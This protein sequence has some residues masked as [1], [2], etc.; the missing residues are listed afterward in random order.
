MKLHGKTPSIML[1][2]ALISTYF[3]TYL[4]NGASSSEVGCFFIFGDSQSD[5]GNNNNNT[6]FARADYKPYGIDFSKE[7]KPTGRFTNGRN[8]ADFIV[9]FLGFDNY[10]PPFKNMSGWNIL[11]G[12]NYA[13]GAAGIRDE[14]GRTQGER[15]SFNKQL[16]NHNLI[17]SKLQHLLGN[18]IAAE[19]HLK[20]C[21]YMVQIGGNDYLNNYFMPLSYKTSTEFTPHQYATALSKQ[22]SCKLKAL[23][24]Q[25][26]RKLAIF[27]AGPIGCTPYARANFDTKGS[28][29][30]E[31][32]NNAIQLFNIGLKSMVDDL[33]TKLT[34][35][36]F[37]FVDVFNIGT[38]GTPTSNQ[39]EMVVDSPCCEV[40]AGKIQCVPLG[41]VCG[42]RK[43][44]L[45]WDAVHPT[46]IGFMSLA[47]RAYNAKFPNDTHPFDINR[48]VHL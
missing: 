13:S 1:Y 36:K 8:V 4:A 35:A 45:F 5:N 37:I 24:G 11:K 31:E 9:E 20:S 38:H 15:S 10:V 3:S 12:V 6:G 17:I 42:N 48:L 44:Y 18:R 2:Y 23:Y 28:P 14:T 43:Q 19:E 7:M 22:L 40:P 34:N 26:A 21:L 46:E 25:G 39:G 41:K 33:N 30:V 32:I 27:G 16:K 47:S 29:C